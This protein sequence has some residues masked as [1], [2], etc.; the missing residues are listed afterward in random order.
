MTINWVVLD[1]P[2]RKRTYLFAGGERITFLNVTKIEVRPSGFHRLETAD[3]KKA[4]IRSTW[5]S[6]EIDVDA[7]TF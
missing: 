5:L 6:M 1:P 3:G 7:W 2:E 4:F